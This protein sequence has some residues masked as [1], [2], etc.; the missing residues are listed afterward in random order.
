MIQVGDMVRLLDDD[1]EC[2]SCEA[3]RGDYR[4]VVGI[5][6][7]YVRLQLPWETLDF[8]IHWS[9]DIKNNIQENE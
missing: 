9:F 8:P 1:C 3:A 7:G 4:Q 5:S 6:P 2:G